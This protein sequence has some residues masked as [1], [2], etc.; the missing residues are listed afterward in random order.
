MKINVSDILASDGL[1]E[2]VNAEIA[3]DCIEFNGNTLHFVKPVSVCG[4]AKNVGGDVEVFLSAA[5]RFETVC[6]RCLKNFSV[7]F[8][9]DINETF[10][11]NSAHDDVFRI[12]DNEI[13]LKDVVL[14]HLYMNL[15]ISFIC[16]DDCKGLC[17]KCGQNLNEGECSCGS[18]D[19]DPR[20]AALLKFK[21]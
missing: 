16:K 14:Q 15:P 20:M 1:A 13:D 2:N 5:T 4:T 3:A 7:D 6:A 9:Y 19:I 21:K 8:S 17:Q 12:T 18:D 10:V 11:K